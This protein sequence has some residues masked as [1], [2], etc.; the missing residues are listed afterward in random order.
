[1]IFLLMFRMKGGYSL[2]TNNV[3]TDSVVIASMPKAIVDDVFNQWLVP[4]DT[5]ISSYGSLPTDQLN[6]KPL[7]AY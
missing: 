7:K 2:E 1:M 4:K 3:M 5:W 6:S